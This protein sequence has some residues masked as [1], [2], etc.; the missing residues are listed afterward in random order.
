[1]ADP[2][3]AAWR[4]RRVLVT[5]HSGFVG[6]WVAT[7]LLRLGADVV[8]YAASADQQTTCR[9]HWLAALGATTVAGDVRDFDALRAAMAGGYQAVIHLAGQPL[10]SAGYAEPRRTLETNILGSV[11]VLEAARLCQPAVL[12]HV[13]SDKC[14]RNQGWP[15]PYREADGLGGGCPYSVS[16]AAAELVF[17]GYAALFREAGGLPRSASVRFG[18]VIG[19]GDLAAHRLVPD[20]LAALAQE[21]PVRLR[22]A[23]AV[24]PWQHVLDVARG[25]LLLADALADGAVAGGE[26]VNSY[27]VDGG[28][29]GLD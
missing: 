7:M 19:G 3:L 25:L 24:R 13:T 21:R 16:K 8:G 14:Y 10:V 4:G 23:A 12:V 20:C 17:E 26:V 6:S 22:H 1:M 11:N 5:G 29:F 2:R 9:A 28:E 27:A 15:W 18:N